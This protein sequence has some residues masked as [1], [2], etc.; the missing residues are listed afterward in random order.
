MKFREA[1]QFSWD[2]QIQSNRRTG[3]A[4]SESIAERMKTCPNNP[5]NGGDGFD[6]GKNFWTDRRQGQA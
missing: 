6:N 3:N 4:L 5:R 1:S 2:A